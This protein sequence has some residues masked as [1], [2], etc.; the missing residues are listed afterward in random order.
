MCNDP[1][2][3]PQDTPHDAV[4]VQEAD[5]VIA[6]PVQ[7]PKHRRWIILVIVG[8]LLAG[9]GVTAWLCWPRIDLATL[10]G[11]L[12]CAMETEDELTGQRT[13]AIYGMP[14]NGRALAQYVKHGCDVRAIT[15]RTAVA[16]TVTTDTQ[17]PSPRGFLLPPVHADLLLAPDGAEMMYFDTEVDWHGWGE[18]AEVRQYGVPAIDSRGNEQAVAITRYGKTDVFTVLAGRLYE[19][20]KDGNAGTEHSSPQLRSS[21]YVSGWV[22]NTDPQ[23]SP[24]NHYLLFL[25]RRGT[26]DPTICLADM[27]T[28]VVRELT[29]GEHPSFNPQGDM[30]VFHR[31]SERA[32]YRIRVDGQGAEQQLAKDAWCP[33]Y[34]P[35][36]QYIAYLQRQGEQSALY[37][38]QAD[39]TKATKML[40]VP[41]HLQ[42]LAW[43]HDLASDS[44]MRFRLPVA[45]TP[46]PDTRDAFYASLQDAGAEMGG[47][48]TQT[49]IH[50]FLGIYYGAIY[51][52]AEAGDGADVSGMSLLFRF[53]PRTKQWESEAMAVDEESGMELPDTARTAIRWQVP[54]SF[55]DYWH[56]EVTPTR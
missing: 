18:P 5:G 4:P 43:V 51:L 38:M 17:A 14:A 10:P 29:R 12:V 44:P 19:V 24:T 1:Q 47:Q 45:M 37:V 22:A 25:K 21:P 3:P 13:W 42:S 11:Q 23:F 41:G 40:P 26:A 27:E 7:P 55:L 15:S 16:F 8:L 53:N 52:S 48:V 34:S 28:R 30:L 50:E 9:G 6:E 36:G 39:G 20:T 33:T 31:A 35:D 32:I 49:R 46:L 56:E 2:L 54:Q